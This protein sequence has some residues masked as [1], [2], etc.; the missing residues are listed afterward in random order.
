V[1]LAEQTSGRIS[2]PVDPAY[3]WDDALDEL[4]RSEPSARVINLET[5]ITRSADYWKGKGI[6][7]RMHPDNIACLT[8]ARIDV[9]TLA[10]NHVLD[11]AYE[12]LT[13]TIE[14]LEHAG[15]RFA[16]SGLNLGDACQPAV[17]DFLGG[18]LFVWSV[19]TESS[20]SYDVPDA[21]ISFA[22]RL[23]EKGIDIV[24]G[25]S[26]HRGDL[27]LMYFPTVD[28]ASGEILSVGIVP[29][30]VRKMRLNRAS[31]SDAEWL[32]ATVSHASARFGCHVDTLS[33]GRLA[34]RWGSAVQWRAS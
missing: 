11:Y 1:A 30:R 10:N 5:S 24:H 33:D 29:M 17:V 9:C 34:L 6:N 31:R 8:A 3:V 12:G 25:H 27:A 2:Q 14:A 23:I 28:S 22:H 32:Q 19:G 4:D 13:E 16:G 15:L 20:G 26:L 7:Y 18:H 21:H